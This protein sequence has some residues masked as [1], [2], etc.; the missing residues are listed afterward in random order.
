MRF[1]GEWETSHFGPPR[2]ARRTERV[3][4]DTLPVKIPYGILDV[5]TV[6]RETMFFMSIN[7]VNKIAG[8]KRKL[9]VF[10]FLF[11]LGERGW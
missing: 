5:N 8:T 3:L 1:G 6:N 10:L 4:E 7:A 9:S 11:R 2:S